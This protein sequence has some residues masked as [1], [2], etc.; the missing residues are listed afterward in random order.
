MMQL[1]DPEALCEFHTICTRDTPL[2]NCILQ[3]HIIYPY[4]HILFYCCFTHHPNCF[5]TESVKAEKAEQKKDL[6]QWV[7]FWKVPGKSEPCI[8]GVM[9]TK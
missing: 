3:Y 2:H 8:P 5:R 6:T 7:I 4:S 1:S 9:A